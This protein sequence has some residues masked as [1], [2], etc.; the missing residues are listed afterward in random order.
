MHSSRMCTARFRRQ[1]LSGGKGVCRGGCLPRVGC[2]LHPS[3]RR[4]K[5]ARQNITLPQTSFVGGK[6]IDQIRKYSSR[7]HTVHCSNRHGGGGTSPRGVPAWGVYLPRGMY[8]PR[9]RV[10]IPACT[11]ADTPSVNRMTD[12]CKNNFI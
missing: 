7:M 3:P 11:E 5:D 2:L 8:L 1:W 12:R 9:G 4:Q 6:N 10:G